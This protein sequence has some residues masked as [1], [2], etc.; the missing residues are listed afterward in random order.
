[1]SLSVQRMPIEQLIVAALG[2]RPKGALPILP[3]LS[4]GA[5]NNPVILSFQ[6]NFFCK[7]AALQK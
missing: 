7:I 1:M 6:L 5:N 4:R 3:W 2:Q